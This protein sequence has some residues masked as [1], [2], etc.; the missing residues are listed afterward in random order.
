MSDPNRPKRRVIV[1]GAGFG[2][3]EVC[4]HLKD[5]RYEV[6]LVDRQNHH[7]FQPLLYQVATCG[8]SAP[9]IAQPVRE[10]FAKQKNVRTVM[11]EVKAIDPE[12]KQVKLRLH[13]L[14]YDY[15][16][17]ALGAVT[18]YFGND[19]W[20]K[21][22]PGL[23]SLDDATRIRRELLLAFER[24]ET[25]TDLAER[26]RLMTIVVVGGGPTGVEMAGAIVELARHVLAENFRDIDPAKAKVILVEAAP[27]V[28][29]MFPGDL[30]DYTRKK[31]TEMG[32]DVRTSTMV[33]DITATTVKLKDGEEIQAANVIWGAGVQ[34]NPLAKSLGTPQSRGGRLEVKPDLSLPGYPSVFAI[35]DI[36]DCTDANGVSVPGVSPGAIQMGQH[37][38]KVIETAERHLDRGETDMADHLRPKFVYWD[39]GMMATIGRSAAVAAAGKMRMKGFIAW[40][41]WLFVHIIFLVGFRNRLVV[42][43]QWLYSYTNYKRGARIVTGMDERTAKRENIDA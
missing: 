2:G 26:A 38:A 18:S 17:I 1:L 14:D 29:G 13:T 41:A 28:L 16:V 34:A 42:L 21:Y 4:K 3:L 27:A 31:L 40:L 30:P 6:T 35:G 9:E 32:V 24:A 15:L 23:K 22:A 12:K 8:L 43:F 33:E 25:E 11:D 39:K 10:I 36:V 37:V 5:P 7:L 19:Q 20:A